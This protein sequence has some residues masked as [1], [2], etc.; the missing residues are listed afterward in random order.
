MKLAYE[1]FQYNVE[2]YVLDFAVVDGERRLN[3]EVDGEYYHR[4]WDNEICL[5]DQ[6]RN[7]RLSELGWDVMRF[8]VYQVRDDLGSCIQ[9]IQDWLRNESEQTPEK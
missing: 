7:Q 5:R 3:I 6:L 4:N 1:L 8:W 2:K 9:K